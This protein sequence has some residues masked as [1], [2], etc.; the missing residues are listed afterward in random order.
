MQS[1]EVHVANGVV[2]LSHTNV[3]VGLD[4][5]LYK[6]IEVRKAFLENNRIVKLIMSV[7]WIMRNRYYY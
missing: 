1:D 2:K 3:D 6:G 4:L 5:L 7:P